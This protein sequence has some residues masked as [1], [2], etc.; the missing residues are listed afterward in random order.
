M[1]VW[2]GGEKWSVCGYILKAQSTE[3]SD[4]LDAGCHVKFISGT[5]FI[6]IAF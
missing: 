5:E 2:W 3:F 6:Q 1:M 4:Q